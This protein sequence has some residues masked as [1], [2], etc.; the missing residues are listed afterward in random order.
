MCCIFYFVLVTN[1]DNVHVEYSNIPQR[2]CVYCL[3]LSGSQAP[4]SRDINRDPSRLRYG[5]PT[6]YTAW[7]RKFLQQKILGK[8]NSIIIMVMPVMQLYD[9]RIVLIKCNLSPNAIPSYI[10]SRSIC[11]YEQLPSAAVLLIFP[12]TLYETGFKSTA[13]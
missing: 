9:D 6:G 2:L 12:S 3:Q 4:H 11:K 1:V 8:R 5:Q 10:E 7:G 13:K